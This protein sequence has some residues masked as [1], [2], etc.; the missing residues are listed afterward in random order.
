MIF[1]IGNVYAQEDMIVILETNQ[2]AIEIKLMP[3]VTPKA[4]EN[5][6]K[7]VERIIQ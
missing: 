4:C 5:F 1:F 6:V 7:L 2:G 3:E